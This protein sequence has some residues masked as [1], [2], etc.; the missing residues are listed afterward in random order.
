MANFGALVDDILT[1]LNDDGT[2]FSR[3]EILRWLSEGYRRLANQARH[4]RTFTAMDMPPRHT[5]AYSQPWEYNADR[6]QRKWTFTHQN[7]RS[8]CTFLWEAQ[9]ADG[10]ATTNH[11]RN[12]TNLWELSVGEGDADVHYRFSLPRNKDVIHTVWHDHERLIATTARVLDS[13]EDKWWNVSGEPQHWM[14]GLDKAS[15]FEVY[16][17]ETEYIQ[18]YDPRNS[19]FGGPRGF[20]GDRAYEVESDTNSWG[21]AYSWSNEP[22]APSTQLTGIGRRF[23]QGPE[24]DTRN[25]NDPG[26]FYTHDWEGQAHRTETI[27]ASATVV[28]TNPFRYDPG[29][30]PPVETITANL[31]VGVFRSAESTQRQY[32]PS[33]QWQVH[34]VARVFN[35]SEN[36]ILVYHSV[37]P[38]DN[39][40]EITEPLMIPDQMQKYLSYFALQVLFNRQ[41]EGYDPALASHYA[42][43][44]PRGVLIMKRL[45]GITRVAESYVRGQPRA[46]TRSRASLPQLP[47]NFPRAP[48]LR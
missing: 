31:E 4:A 2:L 44:S 1:R 48:W 37:T 32:F 17:I 13:L 6:T 35:S 9:Q 12:V 38:D 25:S 27:T 24:A 10:L 39:I 40:S 33:E 43:R 20:I 19:E 22:S 11:L 26:F 34:G 41:G 23:T 21:Y 46:T 30:D 5:A 15:D 45:G 14:R 28:E 18:G 8:E 36:N 7:G 16:E 47:S 42:L 29:T 3:A